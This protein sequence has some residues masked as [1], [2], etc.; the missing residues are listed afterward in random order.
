M[1]NDLKIILYNY[2]LII[3]IYTFVKFNL[4]IVFKKYIGLHIYAGFP[5]DIYLLLTF[6]RG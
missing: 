3:I 4:T 6:E 1:L 5:Y 2:F